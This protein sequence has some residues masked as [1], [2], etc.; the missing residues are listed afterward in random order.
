MTDKNKIKGLFSHNKELNQI[1]IES[2]LEALL[3][4]MRVKKFEEISITEICDRAGI[5]RNAFYKNFGT[6]TNVFKKIVEHFIKNLLKKLGN[7]F[8]SK[9]TLSW[10]QEFFKLIKKESA[11]LLLFIDEN[12]QNFYLETVNKILTSNAELDAET[13]YKR[14]MW[15]GA[16]QNVISN[17]LRSGMVESTDILAKI[18]Y[19]KLKYVSNKEFQILN[20]LKRKNSP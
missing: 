10:Y 8:N 1:T 18:C 12:F 13:K 20:F 14:I 19:D 17:W 4:L 3:Q 15:N 5:S 11:K 2:T 16:I 7:P 6:K 9:V